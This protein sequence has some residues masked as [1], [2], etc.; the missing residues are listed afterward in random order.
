MCFDQS[1]GELELLFI[2]ETVKN[3]KYA[4]KTGPMRADSRFSDGEG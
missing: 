2:I 1:D 4:F 3:A